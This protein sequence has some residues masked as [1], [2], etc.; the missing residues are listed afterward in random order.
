MHDVTDEAPGAAFERAKRHPR[1]TLS[2]TLI[3]KSDYDA[4]RQRESVG[5]PERNPYEG[6]LRYWK[7]RSCGVGIIRV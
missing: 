1:V 4:E 6:W 7:G 3:D 5:L 2:F